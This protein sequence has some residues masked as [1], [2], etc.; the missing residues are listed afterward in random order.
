MIQRNGEEKKYFESV[1]LYSK[2]E[3][4][5]ALALKGFVE[6]KIFGNF[7]GNNFDLETSPRIIIIA[8]K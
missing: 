3:L 8:Q 7:N 4:L 5:E 2:E 1:R 6:R